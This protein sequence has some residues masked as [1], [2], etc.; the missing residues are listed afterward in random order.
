M[1][2]LTHRAGIDK[3]QKHLFISLAEYMAEWGIDKI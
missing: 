2:I 1:D 3:R